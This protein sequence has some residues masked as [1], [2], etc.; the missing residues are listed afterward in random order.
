MTTS[1]NIAHAKKEEETQRKLDARAVSKTSSFDLVTLD[2]EL[3]LQNFEKR[4]VELIV[5]LVVPGRPTSASDN[6]GEGA[7]R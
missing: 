6:G 4:P 5:S 7:R 3:R 1:V 2:G